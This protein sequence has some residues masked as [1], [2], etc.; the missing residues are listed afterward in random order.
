LKNSR[1]RI[2]GGRISIFAIGDQ[3]HAGFDN[4]T[5]VD[6][7][8]MLAAEDRGDTLHDQLNILD[9][10]WAYDLRR[11]NADPVRFIALGRDAVASDQSGEDNE[12]TGLFY[13][14]GD[15]SVAGILGHTSLDPNISR[16]FFTQQHGDN[17]VYEVQATGQ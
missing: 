6:K 4:L 3:F 9:S 2:N 5:F 1:Q 11:P 16:L 7:N 8:T 12:P 14:D 15:P 17:T 10:V 13:S